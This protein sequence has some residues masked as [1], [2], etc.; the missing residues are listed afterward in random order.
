MLSHENN[1]Y[2]EHGQY[3]EDRHKT[4]LTPGNKQYHVKVFYSH[5]DHRI[6]ISIDNTIVI[7]KYNAPHA[8]NRNWLPK[9]ISYC[10]SGHRIEHWNCPN[11]SINKL[12]IISYSDYCKKVGFAYCIDHES[13]YVQQIPSFLG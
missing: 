6:Q 4:K 7:D 8:F 13:V 9:Q 5:N 12:H 3:F 11:V 1:L 2:F 10:G